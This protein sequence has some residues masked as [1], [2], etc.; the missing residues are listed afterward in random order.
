MVVFDSSIIIDALR[1]KKTALDLIESYSGK[2]RIAITV[3]S[4]YEILRGTPDRDAN[5]VSGLIRQF[6]ILNFEDS[7]V[8]AVVKAYRR[9]TE[10]GRMV[11]EFDLLIAGIA[12]A[13]NET[14]ITKDR[15][16][17]NFESPK[18]IVLR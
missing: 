7:V 12:A 2:E 16:F 6:I 18:I 10:K 3:I 9:L 14:L 5:L 11:N 15:D 4:K 17:L 13:N 8:D 1:G